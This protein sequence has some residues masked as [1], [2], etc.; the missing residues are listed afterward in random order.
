M[1]VRL[2]TNFNVLTSLVKFYT[3][4]VIVEIRVI[5]IITGHII[6]TLAHPGLQQ[7]GHMASAEREPIMGVWGYAT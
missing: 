5:T 6:M 4:I 1:A 7:G 2:N 3:S